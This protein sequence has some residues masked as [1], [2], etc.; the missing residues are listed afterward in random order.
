MKTFGSYLFV[1]Q[2]CKFVDKYTNNTF[3]IKIPGFSDPN[4]TEA[5]KRLVMILKVHFI[6]IK[7]NY[8]RERERERE[9]PAIN[10]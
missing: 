10:S 5:C 2:I 1:R 6:I 3:E 8:E 4:F 9:F 7:K